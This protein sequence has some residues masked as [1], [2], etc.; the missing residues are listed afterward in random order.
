MFLSVFYGDLEKIIPGLSVTIPGISVHV[1]LHI[2]KSLFRI[3]TSYG[4]QK[5]NYIL[6]TEQ[7]QGYTM[8]NKY[9]IICVLVQF[10]RIFRF[11]INYK[12]IL[13]NNKLF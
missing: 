2:I 7:L 8:G 5:A 13:L 1:V 9:K 3:L 10:W 6:G 12:F 11:I 4:M